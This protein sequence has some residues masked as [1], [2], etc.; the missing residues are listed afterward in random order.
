MRV[1]TVYPEWIVG[2]MHPGCVLCAGTSVCVPR[3]SGS[4]SVLSLQ[5]VA[6]LTKP[7]H[8][9]LPSYGEKLHSPKLC[10]K[11]IGLFY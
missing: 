2:A 7:N 9:S 8:F 10:F 1:G 4:C 6:A 3:L 11:G 5:A